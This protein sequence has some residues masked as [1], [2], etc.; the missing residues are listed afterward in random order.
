[1]FINQYTNILHLTN[2]SPVDNSRRSKAGQHSPNQYHLHALAWQRQRIHKV[3]NNATKGCKYNRSF[4]R[5]RR[6]P[7]VEYTGNNHSHGG[8]ADDNAGTGWIES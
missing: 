3:P 4:V 6:P 1:M 7:G 5:V 8:H 2:I